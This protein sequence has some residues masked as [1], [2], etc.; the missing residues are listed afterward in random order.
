I[1]QDADM[2]LFV[3]RPEYYHIFQDEKGNDLHGM[4]QIII[5][6]HRKGATGDVLLNFR[7]EYTR[8]Q[9]PEDAYLGSAD[10]GG[11]EIVGSRMNDGDPLLPPL[12]SDGPVPF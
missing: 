5:A 8:F 2:V 12:P 11:G 7:G 6:K 1:E 4:A 10:G 9:N 3:H